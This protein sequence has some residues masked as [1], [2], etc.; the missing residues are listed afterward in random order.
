MTSSRHETSGTICKWAQET[1][2]RIEPPSE[3]PV[4]DIVRHARRAAFIERIEAEIS[5]LQEAIDKRGNKDG[6]D[7]VKG[8]IADVM[9]LTLRMLHEFGARYDIADVATKLPDISYAESML[10][11]KM[12]QATAR[13]KQ[14]AVS[15]GELRAG[16]QQVARECQRLC[17]KYRFDVQAI[18]DA[19]MATNRQ[20]DWQT[21]GF[22][23]GSHR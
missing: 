4:L 12:K 16:L 8:E 18:I 21:D 3:H 9:I 14:R 11:A 5:E 17:K 6:M 19:K 2:G 22:G 13:S 15:L 23:F 20:R 1:F 7:A 10:I